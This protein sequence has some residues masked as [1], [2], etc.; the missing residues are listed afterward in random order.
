MTNMNDRAK[1]VVI[2]SS[3]IS[4]IY[5]ANQLMKAVNV[6]G[7][8]VETQHRASSTLEKFNKLV[9]RLKNPVGLVRKLRSSSASKAYLDKAAKINYDGFGDEG[10]AVSEKDGVR[11]VHTEGVRDINAPRNVEIIRRMDPDIIA[12][13]GASILKNPVI[14][15]PRLG[16]LNLHGGLSQ[17][18][19]GVWTT[20]WAIYNS[21]P[22][23]VGATVH[24]I[25][26]NI[27]E[28]DIIFQGRPEIS[29]DDNHES[30]YVKVVK[31][32]ISLMVDAI[33]GIEDGTV[34]RHKLKK[35]GALYLSKRVT[36][37]I[38]KKAWENIE[39]GVIA[40]YLD[41]RNE[42]DKKV[43]LYE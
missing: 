25:N 31:I 8:V 1:V 33:K 28:G 26:K 11:I 24:H 18:Y 15:I 30:L 7:V 43:K 39:S 14:E 9:R 5:F 21:E 13:C 10:L 41:N 3:D 35:K 40:E 32:G 23:Y 19:R 36:P 6:V 12:V 4:D 16:I 29:P 27:D 38:I 34:K 22:E 2:V 37:D 17:Q 42:R 20:M